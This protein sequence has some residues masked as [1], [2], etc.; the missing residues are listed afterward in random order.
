MLKHNALPITAVALNVF[1]VIACRSALGGNVTE[2]TAWLALIVGFALS[3]SMTV[4]SVV[5]MS[6]ARR[7]I[8]ASALVVLSFA[9]CSL[10]L[11]GASAVVR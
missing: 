8:G 5:F 2:A 6:S 7:P 11:I 10:V 1:T 9:L 3:F 4:I